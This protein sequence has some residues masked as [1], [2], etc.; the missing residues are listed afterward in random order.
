MLYLQPRVSGVGGANHYQLGRLMEGGGYK[1]GCVTFAKISLA[2]VHA[3]YDPASHRT[4]DV[5]PERGGGRWMGVTA[6]CR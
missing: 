1:D 5:A 6:F 3:H 2:S 4:V